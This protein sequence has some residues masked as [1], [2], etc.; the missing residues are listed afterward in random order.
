MPQ[1]G[2]G[3]AAPDTETHARYLLG[4]GVLVVLLGAL[5]YRVYPP[6]RG[7]R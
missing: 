4:I 5:L 7:D 3:S 2:A 6:W 1:T